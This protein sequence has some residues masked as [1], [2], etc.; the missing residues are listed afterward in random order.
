MMF[1]PPPA[2]AVQLATGLLDLLCSLVRVE[3]GRS[4]VPPAF[5]ALVSRG[6]ESVID[7]LVVFGRVAIHIELLPYS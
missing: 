1:T 6:D 3:A 2:P 5:G 7:G 4:N